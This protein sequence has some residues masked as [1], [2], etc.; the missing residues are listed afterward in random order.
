M[1]GYYFD[2]KSN[3]YF[4]ISSEQQESKDKT[5]CSLQNEDVKLTPKTN[6]MYRLLARRQMGITFV[7]D[8]IQYVFC[9][10]M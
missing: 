8:N 10:H 4:K 2:T 9:M 1:P 7:F 5:V 6:N 3:K